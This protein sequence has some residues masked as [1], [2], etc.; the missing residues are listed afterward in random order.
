MEWGAFGAM[1]QFSI[2]RGETEM[3][4]T[5]RSVGSEALSDAAQRHQY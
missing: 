1:V 4:K 3:P 2:P 5:I